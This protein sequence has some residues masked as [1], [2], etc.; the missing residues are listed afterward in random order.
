MSLL[1]IIDW[2][3]VVQLAGA[4]AILG[5]YWTM[6]SNVKRASALLLAGCITW[7]GW[8]FFVSPWPV[9]LFLLEFILGSMSARTLWIKFRGK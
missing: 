7:A 3:A 6:A 2:S 9:Y 1:A 8:T 5:G 4:V